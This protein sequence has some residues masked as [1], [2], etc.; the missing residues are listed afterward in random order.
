M[1]LGEATS[2]A[3]VG[4]LGRRVRR[5]PGVPPGAAVRGY[6]RNRGAVRDNRVCA[7]VRM[8]QKPTVSDVMENAKDKTFGPG[9]I[10]CVL[11]V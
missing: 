11:S 6:V 2:A 7:G 10:A 9:T 5:P 3:V 8:S 4:E 1:T